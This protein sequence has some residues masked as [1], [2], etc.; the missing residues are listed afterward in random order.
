MAIPLY[1][2][3]SNKETDSRHSKPE[4]VDSVRL[5]FGR[6]PGIPAVRVVRKVDEPS[7]QTNPA[8]EDPPG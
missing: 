4:G 1:R 2:I 8:K 6:T 3:G 5:Y 7:P